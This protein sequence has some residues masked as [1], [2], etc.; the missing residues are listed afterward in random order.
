[1]KASILLGLVSLASASPLAKRAEPAP[2]HAR[3]TNLIADDYIV[4]FKEGSA[5]SLL[6]DALKH[7]PH[8]PN[9]KFESVFKGFSSKLDAAS[10]AFFRNHPD[11]RKIYTS[12]HTVANTY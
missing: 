7:L 6:E 12:L 4:K 3:G 9:H 8:Q 5:L 10:L 11:V 2:L 1:M